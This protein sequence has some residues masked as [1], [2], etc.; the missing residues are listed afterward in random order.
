MDTITAI[1]PEV[2]LYILEW[3]PRH[4]FL[5]RQVCSLWRELLPP[6]T[7]SD[8]LE[9]MYYEGERDLIQLYHLPRNREALVA[10]ARGNQRQLLLEN[11]PPGSLP[12]LGPEGVGR[13]L[14]EDALPEVAAL[15]GD[16][17][18]L[19]WGHSNGY[20]HGPEVVDIAVR[21]KNLPMLTWCL[22]RP[23]ADDD[24]LTGGGSFPYNVE[25]L[26]CTTVVN[27]LV[28]VAKLL[29]TTI[30]VEWGVFHLE[31][32]VKQGFLE[33][34][35]WLIGQGVVPRDNSLVTAILSSRVELAQFL[36]Q[37]GVR[38]RREEVRETIT[39]PMQEW[40]R[41]HLG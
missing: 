37:R 20:I 9:G 32:A 17:D 26:V 21:Q 23:T 6:A 38:C 27:G 18:L 39:V 19:K 13:T 33:L 22:Q 3:M 31:L 15:L 8:L 7:L 14:F 16:L 35:E 41:Q 28:E 2:Q 5:L 1:T 11:W 12:P 25:Q 24:L 30:K 34:V 36:W 10:A 40:V 4:R 29:T